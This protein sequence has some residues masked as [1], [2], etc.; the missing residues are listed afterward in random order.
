MNVKSGYT[1]LDSISHDS[2]IHI[3]M[4]LI[5]EFLINFYVI[6]GNRYGVPGYVSQIYCEGG[7]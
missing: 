3:M 5:L 7:C 4:F 6:I 1:Y 2:E